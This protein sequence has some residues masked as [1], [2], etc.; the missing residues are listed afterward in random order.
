MM[1][2]RIKPFLA[3]EKQHQ[4]DF[5]QPF[6]PENGWEP[7]GFYSP[8]HVQKKGSIFKNW[9]IKIQA[10]VVMTFSKIESL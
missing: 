2:H 8:H 4:L 6:S 5:F 3:P 9:H 7:G 1:G 10:L